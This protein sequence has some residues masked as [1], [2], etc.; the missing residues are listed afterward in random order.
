MGI[1]SSDTEVDQE[2][3]EAKRL[4]A[5]AK[6]EKK[7]GAR[8][9]KRADKLQ[10]DIARTTRSLELRAQAREARSQRRAVNRAE[11]KARKLSDK[12]AR[13]AAK[14]ALA[15]T[16]AEKLAV[17]RSS[18]TKDKMSKRQAKAKLRATRLR[19]KDRI[20]QRE[21]DVAIAQAAAAKAEAGRI[22]KATVTRAISV[23]QT[24]APVLMPLVYKATTA[25]KAALEERGL[26]TGQ[27]GQYSGTS[28]SGVALLRR[29]DELA[30]LVHTLPEKHESFAASTAGRLRD[31][32]SSVDAA[33]V[34]ATSQR[35]TAHQ[36]ISKELDSVAS[37]VTKKA[38]S[39]R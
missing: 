14:V 39:R 19:V 6:E 23:G 37:Q 38:S 1:F 25:G 32:R 2:R 20:A 28:A 36:A 9:E 21:H 17:L 24:L 10:R 5:L 12:Q 18:K 3:V 4:K 26:N 33:E 35:R 31:I 27:A 7:E 29:V 8:Q 13:R 16:K 11:T 15:Q 22:N 34:M 30:E